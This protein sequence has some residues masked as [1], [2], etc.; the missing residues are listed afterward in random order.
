MNIALT[1]H[2]RSKRSGAGRKSTLGFAFPAIACVCLLSS[3]NLIGTALGLGLAK[4]Q[5]G[6]LP[7]GS[8]IDTAAGPV[9]IEKLKSGDVITGFHGT[10]VRITQIHQ[11]HED[12]ATSYYLTIHFA[13]GSV[14]SA[15]PRH[16]IDGIPACELDVGES[17]GS[18]VVA[19]IEPLRGVSR[20]FDLLTE[21]P[22]YR[23]AGIP[24]NSMIE[25]MLG[26]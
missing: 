12:P 4:L 3:C 2:P 22:G 21:D 6:C 20:S 23:I 16:R 18:Q 8:S 15:S 11:Y 19:R 7:Q 17:C 26:R 13:N 5:F 10:P 1:T 9:K 24:V 14:V 25:E